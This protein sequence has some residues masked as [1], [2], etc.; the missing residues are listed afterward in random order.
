M[1]LIHFY[2]KKWFISYV[3]IFV[4][5]IF[6]NGS[7]KLGVPIVT[8]IDQTEFEDKNPKYFADLQQGVYIYFFIIRRWQIFNWIQPW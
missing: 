2:D 8:N 5:Y 3:R 7:L 6:L 4:R 1:F